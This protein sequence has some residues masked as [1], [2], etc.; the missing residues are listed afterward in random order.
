MMQFDLPTLDAALDLDGG[1]DN[2]D[3]GATETA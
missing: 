2:D 3:N 1:D